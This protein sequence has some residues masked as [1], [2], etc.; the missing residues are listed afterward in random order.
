[1]CLCLQVSFDS[2]SAVPMEGESRHF[3]QSKVSVLAGI[4]AAEVES[5]EEEGTLTC[6]LQ[7]CWDVLV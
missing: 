1:M 4:Q 3:P 5:D 7:A 6:D 2:H